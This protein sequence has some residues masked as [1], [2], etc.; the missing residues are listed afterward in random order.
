MLK[1]EKT[2]SKEESMN[3]KFATEISPTKILSLHIEE[4]VTVFFL[5]DLKLLTCC[6]HHIICFRPVSGIV[7]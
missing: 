5:T 6:N 4:N 1:V 2:W 7:S 3:V